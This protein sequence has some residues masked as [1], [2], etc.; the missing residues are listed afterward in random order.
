MTSALSF[1]II[2]VPLPLS[3]LNCPSCGFPLPFGEIVVNRHGDGVGG[4]GDYLDSGCL[5]GLLWLPCDICRSLERS[6]CS[7]WN[8]QGRTIFAG[9]TFSIC[10]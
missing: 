4:G 10:W 6:N 3:S 9:R 2:P 8:R 5:P 7:A 1:V